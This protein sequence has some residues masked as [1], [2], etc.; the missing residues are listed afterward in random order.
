MLKQLELRSTFKRK[1]FQN[2]AREIDLETPAVSEK[3]IKNYFNLFAE[4]A[5]A[6]C[7]PSRAEGNDIIVQSHYGTIF[8]PDY[9]VP[10]QDDTT[11]AWRL[12]AADGDRVRLRFVDF[13]LGQS[14]VDTKYSFCDLKSGMDY[15]EIR[16]GESS[17]DKRL[18]SYYGKKTPFDVYSSGRRMLIK[19]RANRDGVQAYRGFKA[20]FESVKQRKFAAASLQLYTVQPPVSGHPKCQA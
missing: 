3:V 2:K 18:G 4:E 10:Y 17:A 5:S 8:S 16:D 12:Y 13:E 7:R 14:V 19:F 11:C 15:V 6:I 9:P 1:Q 20:H